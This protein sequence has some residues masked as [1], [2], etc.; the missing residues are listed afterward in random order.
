MNLSARRFSSVP[1]IVLFTVALLAT[2]TAT[3]G[4][5]ARQ[6]RRMVVNETDDGGGSGPTMMMFSMP[7]FFALREPDFA[8]KDVPTFTEQL[9]LSEPQTSHFGQMIDAYLAEFEKLCTEML[10]QLP[11][12]IMRLGGPVGGDEG[13]EIR[14]SGAIVVSPAMRAMPAGGGEADGTGDAE[15][16]LDEML[17]E[18]DT[19]MLG[20]RAIGVQVSIG[21][22]GGG[23]DDGDGDGGASQN[24]GVSVSIAP[25]QGEDISDEDRKRLQEKAEK[26]AAQIRK[27]MEEREAAGEGGPGAGGPMFGEMDPEMMRQEHEA[28][29]LKAEE[30]RKAKAALRHQF[31]ND[32]QVHLAGSQI[33]RWPNIERT[34]RRHKTLPT[35]RLSGERTDLVR[36]LK[37]MKL[38]EG[39]QQAVASLSEAYELAM[40]NAL[41]QRNTNLPEFEKQMDQA[42][43]RGDD[44][45]AL[46]A[47]ERA[48]ALRLAVR[49]VNEQ[50]TD[51]IA[52]ALPDAGASGFRADVLRRS[53]PNVYRKTS[54]QKNFDAAK[55]IENLDPKTLASIQQLETGYHAEIE[56]VNAQ[57]KAAIDKHQPDE[58]RWPIEHMKAMREGTARPEGEVI[59]FNRGDNPIREAFTKRRELDMRYIKMIREMLTPEQQEQLP[60]PI[61]KRAGEPIII[62][63]P[64]REP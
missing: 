11:G 42:I 20:N 32:A 40:E 56:G 8:K 50:F 44:D 36:V 53:Y 5:Q 57:L 12:Q 28:M 49:T 1:G 33:E 3:D 39:E 18:M 2:L 16:E 10:P 29:E 55:K 64:V 46:T 62:E 14:P 21:G 38:G 31:V 27:Q 54:G 15:L 41:L 43:K 51:T 48:T 6:G 58:P 9:L 47:V 25:G 19:D 60:K 7:D 52:A 17:S 4:A 30:F 13:G 34:L 23:D 35:G 45:K 59:H 22:P 63:M 37:D 24:G 61:S 26:I